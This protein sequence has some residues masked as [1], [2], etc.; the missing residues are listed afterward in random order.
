MSFAV[1]LLND[2]LC[3][4]YIKNKYI[5][6]VCSAAQEAIAHAMSILTGNIECVRFFSCP[7]SQ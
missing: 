2:V 4:H 5:M 7:I 3:M 1:L 6:V